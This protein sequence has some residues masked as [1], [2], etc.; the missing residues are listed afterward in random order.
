V[1]VARIA[2]RDSVALMEGYHSPQLDVDV[3]LNTNESPVLP[4]PQAFVDAL[5]AEVADGRVAPL[6][7][8]RRHRA[9]HPH[10]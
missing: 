5:A 7:R 10:R 8:P 3:R 4:P 1:T 6:P 2:P 9:A